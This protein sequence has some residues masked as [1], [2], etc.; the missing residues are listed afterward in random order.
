ML[1]DVL[2][3]YTL[4]EVYIGDI[5]A[6]LINTYCV[7]RDD[8]DRI[9]NMLTVLQ[10]EFLP[11]STEERKAYYFAKRDLFN[12]LKASC[13]GKNNAQMA[14]LMIFLNKTIFCDFPLF[15]RVIFFNL[16]KKLPFSARPF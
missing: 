5:N 8:V 1:F 12:E 13:D 2:S 4:E 11:L 16:R 9:I 7:I 3:K 14:A 10:N 6:E 15:K